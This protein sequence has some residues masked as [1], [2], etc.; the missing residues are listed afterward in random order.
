MQVYRNILNH[1]CRNFSY[2]PLGFSTLSIQRAYICVSVCF[3]EQYMTYQV[4][5][6]PSQ[7]YLVLGGKDLSGFKKLTIRAVLVITA[8]AFVSSHNA[9]VINLL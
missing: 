3:S 2:S 6:I 4:G 9:P 5:M 7:Y 8:M 1:H